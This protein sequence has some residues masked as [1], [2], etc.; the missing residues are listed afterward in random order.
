M[1]TDRIKEVRALQQRG[2]HRDALGQKDAP[3]SRGYRENLEPPLTRTVDRWLG[4][5]NR[6]ADDLLYAAR[7]FAKNPGFTLGAVLSLAIGIG[8]TTAI[9]SVLSALLLHPLPYKDADRL[10]I[11]WNRSPGLNITQDWFS[12]A[13]YF[14]IRNGHGGFEDVAIAIGR[15]D[16]LTGDGEPERIGT[17]HVSSNL[18]EMLGARPA[19]G[20][21][22][23]K[24]EDVAGAA[25][26]ALLS[27]GR[28]QRRY[29]GD[30]KVIGKSIAI[31]G[32]PYTL[33]GVTAA[34]FSYR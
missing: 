31:N 5:M 16:N 27:Y 3:A 30:P 32:K 28:W 21:L 9:F 33:V 17:I 34:S 26:T 25:S 20:R 1:N 19:V 18:L 13:Q 22:F 10:V 2:V 15:N 12:T 14:D 8:A 7:G 29:G 24:E 11:L 23:V 6:L 4:A